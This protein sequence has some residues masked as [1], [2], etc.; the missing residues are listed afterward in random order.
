MVL[1]TPRKVDGSCFLDPGPSHACG[2]G[3]EYS[4]AL[5]TPGRSISVALIVRAV[6]CMAEWN[7]PK[8]Q[9]RLHRGTLRSIWHL[10]FSLTCRS[11]ISMTNDCERFQRPGGSSVGEADCSPATA[12]LHKISSDAL[13]SGTQSPSGSQSLARLAI[14]PWLELLAAQL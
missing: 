1:C 11:T 7:P 6:Y 9:P 4:T 10:V 8:F 3:G 14:H 2:Q 12:Q 13:K 5:L